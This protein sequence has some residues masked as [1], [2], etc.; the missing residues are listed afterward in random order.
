MKIQIKTALLYTILTASIILLLSIII[1]FFTS[2]FAFADFYKRLEIRAFIAARVQYDKDKTSQDVYENLRAQHLEKLEGEHEY[3]VDTD[4]LQKA[5]GRLPATFY[6]AVQSTGVANYTKNNVYYTGVLYQDRH[7]VVVSATNEYGSHVMSNLQH[8]LTGV[9]LL[10]VVLIF[11]AGFFFSRSTFRPFRQMTANMQN[12]HAKNLSLRLENTDGKDEIAE[13]AHTFN[14]M[15][16]R[17]E[18]AFESQHNFVSNASHEI[19]TPVTS[20]MAEAE[21]ALLKERSVDDYRRSLESIY[22]QGEKLK[23]MTNSL[24]LLAQI[25]YSDK[26]EDMQPLRMDEMVLE[27]K[28]AVDELNPDNRIQLNFDLLPDDAQQLL[29][30]GNQHLL[31]LALSNVM[32]NACKYSDNKEVEVLL[33]TK[34]KMVEVSVKDKGIGIPANEIK[35]VF[36]PFFRASNT[37]RYQGHGIGLPLSMHIIRH[38]KGK[39]EVHS[40]QGAG[41]TVVISLPAAV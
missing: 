34:N 27:V 2:R 30:S 28:A 41:T 12:I 16:D 17:L 21:V 18:V 23:N 29:V 8:I 22:K 39:I 24:L 15:L 4:T 1:Y 40:S 7:I 32:L 19:R 31:R 10:S 35:H 9:F 25:G 38:H 3:F 11:T 20:I 5:N 6:K 13:L 33:R 14:D 26:R 37:G 36:D